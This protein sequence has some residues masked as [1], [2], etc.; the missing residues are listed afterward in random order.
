M[1]VA[2]RLLIFF[3]N[4]SFN[5]GEGILGLDEAD[6]DFL[7]HASHVAGRSEHRADLGDHA[8]VWI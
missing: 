4:E 2:E 6:I 7:K 1:K 8:V 3:L 5:V